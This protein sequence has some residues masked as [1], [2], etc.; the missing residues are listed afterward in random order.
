M[1]CQ[2]DTTNVIT[3][4]VFCLFGEYNQPIN[5]PIISLC[6]PR[7]T[8]KR[9][10]LVVYRARQTH[11]RTH[12]RTHTHTHTHSAN[13]GSCVCWSVCLPVLP[14]FDMHSLTSY[15]HSNISKILL[16]IMSPE[17]IC[18]Y[19]NIYCLFLAPLC[20]TKVVGSLEWLQIFPSHGF[21][22][23]SLAH[24]YVCISIKLPNTPDRR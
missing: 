22:G 6:M 2:R 8:N 11:T 21:T 20:F 10:L 4:I 15:F 7:P 18:I 16:L 1:Q 5:R 14:N 17:Y 24:S 23:L 3:L 19:I 9:R 13:R 12:A